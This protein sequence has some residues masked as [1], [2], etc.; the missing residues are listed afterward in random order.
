MVFDNHVSDLLP[1]RRSTRR[2][3]RLGDD[4]LRDLAPIAL[5]A[6]VCALDAE[7]VLKALDQAL[8][9]IVGLGNLLIRH[10]HPFVLL[11]LTFLKVVASDFSSTIA[12]WRLPADDT[13]VLGGTDDEGPLWDARFF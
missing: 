10:R 7:L 3:L 9:L 1:E 8:D 13:A 6:H 12:G 5:T 2:L 11:L 4:R